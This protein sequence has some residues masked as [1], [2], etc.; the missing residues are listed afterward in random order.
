MDHF[1][2][3]DLVLEY[4]PRGKV[5]KM[6]LAYLMSLRRDSSQEILSSK[7]KQ[8][9]VVLF[10]DISVGRALK[11]AADLKELGATAAFIPYPPEGPSAAKTR[12]AGPGQKSSAPKNQ[13]TSAAKPSRWKWTRIIF[14]LFLLA[15]AVTL[16]LWEYFPG[17]LETQ[18]IFIPLK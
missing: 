11:I 18:K 5:Q 8:T 14:L 4:A 1:Q 3:G 13:N 10:P 6:V 17:P 16:L 12:F 2:R 15:V 9:P 7:I